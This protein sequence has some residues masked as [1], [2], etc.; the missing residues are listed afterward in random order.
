MADADELTVESVL[1]PDGRIAQRLPAYEHRPQQ[2]AMAQAVARAINAKS[3]LIVEAGTGVGK[4]FSYLVPV[5][6]EA[7]QRRQQE[8]DTKEGERKRIL[9]STHTIALQEQLIGKDIPF[10]NAVLPVEFSAVLAKGRS[11]YISL[12]RLQAA[13]AR[14][15]A[16]FSEPEESRQLS[17][18]QA[19]TKKT[20]D[21][22]R[23]DLDFRP[24]PSVWDEVRSEHGNCLGRKCPTYKDC[25]Y[26]AARRRVWN[27]DL[28]V[29]NHA[30]FFADLALRR[31]GASVLPD[32][33]V[34][35]LDEA[36]TVE[37][38]AGDHLGISVSNGQL[39]Y[40]LG[41]LYNDRT[42]KGLLLHHNLKDAQQMA[43]RLRFVADDF[44]DRI[45][46]W[47]DQS[48]GNGRARE[49][50]KID[51]P[52]TGDMRSLATRMQTYAGKIEDEAQ[53]IELTSA[54]D[55]LIMLS[56]GLDTWLRQ[57]MDDAVY[58]VEISGRKRQIV[59]LVSTPIDIG[60]V[61]RDELFN[62]TNT[63]ILT[64]ATLSVGG[65]SARRTDFQVRPASGQ[66][67]R[68]DLE[69]RPTEW[70]ESEGG[71]AAFAYIRSRLGL[72]KAAELK[73]GSPFDYRRQARLVIATRMPD[74]SR[75]AAAFDRAAGE[76]IKRH[77]LETGGRAFVLFTSYRMLQTTADRLTG[78]FAQQNLTLLCQGE[79]VQ[80][81]ALLE[82]FKSDPRSVLFGTESFW[83][84][85]DVPGDA[86][87]NVIITR[88][89][90]S[91]PD[92]PLLQARVE[93]I[94]ENGG[95][96]F[97]EYQV[98]EAVIKLRQGFGRLIRTQE[99]TGQVVI[100]DPRVR[101]KPYGRTF[102][103]SLPECEVIL[104]DTSAGVSR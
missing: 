50:L 92:H 23:A 44:F 2:L 43:Q 38:V 95:N 77:V 75:E 84:G 24:L 59:E 52:L 90:F 104:D 58:W 14:S 79:G 29:V 21:G 13:A 11:N 61:L 76:R 45:A 22:S 62:Q 33:D 91:V 78:W 37:A 100:L 56:L 1:G 20:P 102:L 39:T 4:S 3:H 27:A 17:R 89:P 9:V 85:V 63:V 12:R 5:I 87:Q 74:P 40:L 46:M 86:L 72:T 60:P 96:P 71:S 25:H 48:G 65:G 73:L 55:R 41:K 94:R 81:T 34:V 66:Q 57:L 98:P 32:Y 42:Q 103:A 64:S 101:T 99:D 69:V 19:W 16:I 31:E 47:R 10:L 18:L 6:L 51:T 97:M 70:E 28:I 83:Q 7:I 54:A 26:Y 67:G 82:Q 68:T 30:L 80:R 15:T 8:R 49:P 93:R 88:L 35:V 53:K 36:H